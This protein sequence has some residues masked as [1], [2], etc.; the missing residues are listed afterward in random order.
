MGVRFLREAR[1]LWELEEGAVNLTNIQA[2]LILGIIYNTDGKDRVGTNFL[3]I[4]VQMAKDLKLFKS[5][6]SPRAVEKS[7]IGMDLTEKMYRGRNFTAWGLF[8]YQA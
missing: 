6:G 1:R 8:N 5:I 3:S 7:P 2:C 4:A